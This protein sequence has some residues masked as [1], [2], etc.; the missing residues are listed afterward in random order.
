[1]TT[2]YGV[3][4]LYQ[5]ANSLK[6]DSMQERSGHTGSSI[7]AA[8]C[9]QGHASSTTTQ[10][11]GGISQLPVIRIGHGLNTPV[12]MTGQL[13]PAITID[14]S[15]PRTLPVLLSA[16][17]LERRAKSFMPAQVCSAGPGPQP[18]AARCWSWQHVQPSTHYGQ[19]KAAWSIGTA[20]L[21]HVRAA[22]DTQGS[23]SRTSA[24]TQAM[25]AATTPAPA[26]QGQA[27][28]KLLGQLRDPCCCGSIDRPARV[29][30]GR[31]CRPTDGDALPRC[32][33]PIPAGWNPRSFHA[34]RPGGCP[35]GRG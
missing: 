31:D 35:H 28:L 8:G 16:G 9:C 2:S 17:E 10:G 11:A 19:V 18:A 25:V 15:H 24:A 22:S 29:P 27:A 1:M 5:L 12:L 33:I 3:T 6:T 34:G 23:V 21:L 26:T 13:T 7:S 32:G 30:D 14:L 4:R 20:H